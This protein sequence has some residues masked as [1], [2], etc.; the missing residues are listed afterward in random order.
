[1]V[2]SQYPGVMVS[3]KLEAARG[4]CSM[5]LPPPPLKLRVDQADWASVEDHWREGLE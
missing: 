4:G 5:P 2:V 3:P 1:M